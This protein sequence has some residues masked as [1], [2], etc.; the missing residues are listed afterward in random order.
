MVIDGLPARVNRANS[1]Q[2]KGSESRGRQRARLP[3]FIFSHRAKLGYP[4]G[5]VKAADQCGGVRLR[6]LRRYVG[7]PAS[8]TE[9]WV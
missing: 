7:Q 5:T 1:L 3:A 9:D 6:F 8:V 4:E 2:I